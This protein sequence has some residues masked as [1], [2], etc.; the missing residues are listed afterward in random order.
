MRFNTAIAAMMEFVNAATKWETR[1]EKALEPFVLCLGPYAPHLSEELW[2]E[3][4]HET[5]NAYAAWPEADESLLVEDTVTMA[6]QVNG[7]M[8]GKIE[9]AVDAAQEDA[10]LRRLRRQPAR[11]RVRRLD[12]QQLAVAVARHHR[13]VRVLRRELQQQADGAPLVVDAVAAAHAAAEVRLRVGWFIG[14]PELERLALPHAAV[15][16]RGEVGGHRRERGAAARH[17]H[18]GGGRV[19]PC[20]V[21]VDLVFEVQHFSASALR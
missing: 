2:A 3:L 10:V 14:Q 7:K 13:R 9:V 8:R 16:P 12:E 21:D 18:V 11:D 15:E 6:V 20:A 1:P 17:G 4:G 5:S 19:R